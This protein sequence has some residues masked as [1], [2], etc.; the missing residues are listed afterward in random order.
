MPSSFEHQ[1]I[2]FLLSVRR[3]TVMDLANATDTA[4]KYQVTYLA[5]LLRDR[6]VLPTELSLATEAVQAILAGEMDRA[7]AERSF[8]LALQKGLTLT[9]AFE[10]SRNSKPAA[11]PTQAELDERTR[12]GR[13]LVSSKII[14]EK[15]LE[16]ALA[17]CAWQNVYLG[18]ALVYINAISRKL[19]ANVLSCQT[20]VRAGLLN[21][22]EAFFALNHCRFADTSLEQVIHNFSLGRQ[23]A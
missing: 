13:L 21:L 8:E 11:K 15:Q 14:T 2:E 7:A 20:S 5:A 3:I 23:V 18:E 1:V 19:L 4:A 22:D 16:T 10:G 6:F 9:E 17:I 12:L